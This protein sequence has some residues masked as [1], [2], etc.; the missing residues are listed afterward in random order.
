MSTHAKCCSFCL[1]C[2]GGL[3]SWVVPTEEAASPFHE[4]LLRKK[5]IVDGS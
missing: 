1:F 2:V 3:V 5:V 4:S